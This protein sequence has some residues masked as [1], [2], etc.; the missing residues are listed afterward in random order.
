MNAKC[1]LVGATIWLACFASAYFASAQTNRTWT[2]SANSDWFNPG[3]WNPVGAPGSNDTVNVSNGTINLT[4]P[5]IINGQL[6]WTGGALSGNSVNITSNGLLNIGGTGS[7]TLENALTNAGTV[8][9]TGTVGIYVYNDNASYSGLIQNLTGGVWNIQSDQAMN[10]GYSYPSFNNAGTVIKSVTTGI[11]T[12]SIAFN[13]TGTVTNLSGTINFSGG[14]A[15]GGAFYAPAGKVFGFTGGSFTTA[16]A[17]ISGAG[18]AQFTGGSLTLLSDI[19]PNLQLTGGTVILG[20]GFQGGTITNLTLAGATLSGTNT[21]GGIMNWTAGVLAGPLT[22]T[23]NGVLSVSGNSTV[24]LYSPLTNA[25]TVNWTSTA[26]IYVYNDHASYSGLIQNLAG[27]VWNIQSDQSMSP[28]YSY[29]SFNNAGSVIKSVTAGTTTFSI[30]FNNTGS[31]T[32]LSGT[33]NFAG[34]GTIGGAFYAA[35]GKAIDFS[36]GNFAS[37]GAVVSGPGTIQ[38]NG[39]SLTL[40][41]DIAPNLQLTGGTVSLGAGFQG[42]TI[43]NFTLAGSTL[44]GTNTLTGIMNWTAG[45]VAGP[46][47]V[48]SNGV[49]NLTGNSAVFLYNPLTNAG[50]VNWTGTVGIYVYNN[51]ASYSGSIQNL[52]GGVWNIQSD[53]SIS[54]G[55]GGAY[56]FSNAGSVIKSVTTGTTTFSI[57]FYNTG[58]VTNLS[59]TLNFAAGGA[60]GETFYA[61]A[62]KAIDFSSGNFTSAGA[63]ISGP[64]TI[65]LNGGSLTLQNDIVP[66]LQLTGGTVSLG[67][68]FQG[69]TIT[70]FALAGSTLSGTNTLT[71]IMNWTAGGVGGPLTVASNGVLNLTGNSTVFLYNPL[72]NAGTVNWTGTVGIYVYNNNAN[73]SGLIQNLAGGVWNIQS[74][75]TMSPG[76]NNPYFN[77]AGTVIKSVTTGTTTFSIPFYNTGMVT[78]LSGTLNFTAGGA[79]GGAFYAAAG[80]AI[81]FSS[82][83]FTSAGAIISGPGTIQLNG[84]NLTLQNDIVP[85]LQLTDGTVNLGA[86]FQGGT[87]TNFTLAGATLSGTNTVSGIL[88]WT[89][90]VV[91]GPLTVASN[92]VLN[93]G[94]NSTVYLYSPLTNAGTVNWTGT[95]GIYVYNNGTS[96]SGLIQNLAGG[97]WNIQ[98]DQSINPGYSNP[99]FSNAGIVTKSVTAGTTTFAIPFYNT[100]T[101]TN[102][103]GT[104][105]FSGG[106]TIGGT[107]YGAAGKTIAFSSGNFSGVADAVVAGPGTIQLNG[108]NLTLPNNIVPNL[109]MT[110]GTVILGTGFQGG[111]IT[112]LTLAGSVLGGSNN[113]VT[114]TFN[115]GGGFTGSL[116]VAGGATMSW[117]GG[118]SGGPLTVAS[119]GVLTLTGNSTVFLYTPLTN[120]GTVN[121]TGTVGIYVY[122]NGTGYFGLI[123]NLAGGV[124]NI[125][126]DQ[127]M[128]PGYSNPYFNNAGIVTKSVTAGTTTFAI[129]FYNTGTVTNLSGT[130]NFAGGGTIGGTFYAAAGKTIDFSSGSFSGLANTVISGPGT[131][132]FNG[133]SLTLQNDIVP[134]LQLTGGTVNLGAGF[135]VGTITNLTLAGSVLGG[136]S[137]TVTGTFNCGGGFTGSLL[138]AGGATMSW[139]GG[140]SGGPLTVASNGVLTLTGN[141]T[142]FLY[143]PLTNAGTVNWTGTV[144]IYV[145][146][147]GTSYSGLIQNLA[148]GLWNIQSDQSMNPGYSYPY[149]S[150]AGLVTKSA[151]TGTTAFSI[152]FTNSGTLDVESGSLAFNGSPAYAQTGATLDFGISNSNSTGHIAISGNVNLDG[153]LGITILN[154]YVPNVGDS[155]SLLSFGSET[156]SFQNLN[157]APLGIGK[158]W[159]VVY[160]AG[161]VQL[162]VV[163]NTGFAYQISGSVND[164][165]GH[166][167]T[168]ITVVAYTTN[169]GASWYVG[170]TTDTSGNYS[171]AVTNG[172]WRVGVQGLPA[173]GYNPLATQSAVVSN[174]NQTVNFVVQPFSGTS[175]TVTTAVNPIG[176]GITT[177]S[178]V[179][180]PGATVTVTATPITTTLPYLFAYWTENGAFESATSS[181]S[182]TASRDRQLLANFTLPTYSVIVS[183][184]PTGAGNVSGA[185]SYFYGATNVLTATP[186]FGY[187]FSNW[188]EGATVVGTSPVLATVIYT[189]HAFVANYAA[190]NLLH[191]ITTATAPPGLAVVSGADTY[192]NGQTASFSAPTSITN[193]PNIFTFQQFTLSNTVVSGAA[194]FN[195]TFSTLDATNLQYVAVYGVRTI[196]PLLTKVGVNFP[197]PVPATT[198]F[199]ITLQFDR[200][201]NPAILPVVVLTNATASL[202]PSVAANGHWTAT[203]QANDTYVTPPITFI[204]GMDGTN[205]LW[206]SGA[207]AANGGLLGLTNFTYFVVDA[208]PPPPALSLIASNSSSATVAWSGYVPPPDLNGFRVFI[209][210]TN[211]TSAALP[212][213]LTV[214]G[215]G[216]RSFPFSA[217]ALDTP[218]YLAVQAVDL[219][220]NGS[221]VSPLVLTLPSSLPPPVS[222]QESPVGATSALLSWNGYNTS[223]LLGFAGFQVFVSGTNFSSVGG[224]VPQAT[225]GP[226]A[227]SYQVNGLNRTNVY[228]FAVVGFNYTNGFNPAVTTVSWSDPYAGNIA[229]NTTIGGAGPSVIPIHHS[230]AVVGGA[231]LTI[232]PGTT[233]LFDPGTGLTVPN[234]SLVANGTALA[235]IVFDSANDSAGG[236]PAP[237]DWN[238]IT[239][240]SGSGSS[241][242]KFVQILYGGGL[243]LDNCAPTVDALSTEYNLPCGLKLQNAATLT[244]ASALVTANGV[245]VE[246]LDTSAL[247]IQNSVL[248]NNVT[249]AVDAGSLPLTATSNWWGTAVQSDVAASLQG[250]VVV[251]PILTDEPL[252]TPAIGTSNGVAQVG[253]PSVNLELACRTAQT[254]RVSEDYTFTGSFFSPFTNSITFPLSAGGGL[255]HVFAQFRSVTGQTNTPVELDVTYITAGPV[256]S[257]FNLGE[258]ETLNRPLI[259]TGSATAALGMLDLEFYVDGVL[260]GTNAGGS[261]SQYFDVRTL[262][263]AIHQVELLARDTAGNI[264]TIENNVVVLVTPP[265]APVITQPVAD[266]GTN[267]NRL[268][269]SG[270]AEP[271]IAIQLTDNGQVLA[272]TNADANGNFTFSNAPLAE[273]VNALLA[274][275]SDSIGIT[276][277]A[278]RHVTVETIPPAALVLGTPVYSPATGLTLTWHFQATGKPATTFQLFWGPTAFSA[279]NQATG[280][281]L[282][283]ST[284]S[285]SVQG[286]A[287]GTYYFGV[288]GYDAVGNPSPLSALVSAV[289]DA[290]PPALGFAYNLPPPVGAGPLGIVLTS[291][292]NL[293][294]T[295]SLTIQPFGAVSPVL[296]SLT[297]VALNTWQSSLNVPAGLPLGTAAVLATA[298][299]QAGN[300]FSGAPSGVPLVIN[301]TPPVG[302]ITTTPPGPIQTTN[303]S[304]NVPISLALSEQV[305][306]GTTPTLSFTPP[307]GTQLAVT[308]GGLGSNWSGTLPLTSAMGSGFGRFTLSAQDSAGNIGTNILSGAQLELYNTALPSPPAAPTNLMATSLPSGQVRLA[309]NVVSNAQIYRLYREPGTNQVPPGVLDLDNLITNSV[310]DLPPAD[311]FYRYGVSASRL[312]AESGISNV[313][314]GRSD[315]TPPAAPTNVTVTLPSSGV[316]ISWQEPGGGETPDHYNLYRNGTRIQTVTS[317]VPVVDYPPR[318]TNTYVVSAADA[319]GNEN[320]S[321]AVSMPLL[322]GTVNNLSVLVE[323]GQAVVLNWADS[324]PTVVGFNVYRNGIRQNVATLTTTSFS[325]NFALADLTQYSVTAVNNA[326]QESPPRK[327]SVSPLGIGLLVN[328]AG[329]GTNHAVLTDYFDQYQIGITNLA[330]AG[331]LPLSQLQLTRAVPGLNPLQIT[332]SLGASVAAG[333]NLQESY[334]IP[335]ASIVAAQTVQVS[336]FQQTDSGGSSVIYQASFTLANVRLPGTQVAV[337]V[338][339][340]PLAGGLTP[341]QVQIYNPSY[342][343]IDVVVSRGNGAQSGDVY[344]SVENSFGQEVSRTPFLGTPLGTIFL[345]D[346]RAY[347]LIPAGSS[348]TFAV[349]NVLVPAALAGSTNTT[350]VVVVSNLYNQIGTTHEGVS[351]PLSGSM[352]SSSL[353]Q[354]PYYGTAQTDKSA[355][356]NADPVLISGQAISQ[357]TGLPVPSAALNIGFATRGYKWYQPVTTDTNGNYHFTYN[358]APGFAGSLSI[359]AADPLVVD[360]LNQ[361]Q[362]TIYRMYANPSTGDIQMSKNGTLSFA[363]RLINPG[364]SL[365]TGVSSSF[366]A[367]QLSGTNQ[368][369]VTKVT[370]TNLAGPSLVIGANQSQTINLELVATIDAPGTVQAQFTFTSAEG[371]SCSFIGSVNLFP[372]VPSLSVVKPSV[373]YLEAS[374]NRGSQL[375]SQI[376]FAN[377][378]LNSLQGV[379]L[380]PPTNVSWMSVNLPVSADGR[381][382]LPDLAMGQS[383]TFSV[384]FNP[385][386]NTP[387]AFYQDAIVIQGTNLASPFSVNVY[388]L[389]TSSLSGNVQFE[390]DDIL[391]DLLTSAGVRLHNNVLQSDAGPFYTDTNGLVT[392][393]N[394]EEGVW[395]WQVTAPGC[396]ASSGTIT[397]IP[398]Q[399]VAQHVRLNRTLVTVN[400]T[401]VPVPFTDQYTIQVNQTYETFVPLPVM[402]LTP[403]YQEFHNV[404]PG[405]TAT[406]TVATKNQGLVQMT[407]LNIAGAQNNSSIVTPLISYLPVLLPMQSVDIPFTVTFSGTNGPVRQDGGGGGGCSA[408]DS[409]IGENFAS[410]LSDAFRGMGVCPQ[411]ATAVQVNAAVNTALWESGSGTDGGLSAGEVAYVQCVIASQTGG[412]GGASFGGGDNGDGGDG[413]PDQGEEPWIGWPASGAG[414]GCFAP[415]TKVLMADG[416]SKPIS[417]IQPKDLVRSGERADAISVVKGIYSLDSATVHELHLAG[418]GNRALTNLIATEEHLVWVDGKGWTAVGNLKAG[419]WLFNSKGD[420]ARVTANRSISGKMRVYTLKLA[421]DIAF[422]AGDVLVHDLC[423]PAPSFAMVRTARVVK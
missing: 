287:N 240:G 263:N 183:N 121:W 220:G 74:D 115:C 390:V 337:S 57:P 64:G 343:D 118:S 146:N 116:L 131:I 400:F 412:G 216:A 370:G 7:V 345:P 67:A 34:G 274:V 203:A 262:G 249:N 112:N 139:S 377:Q 126:S 300:V 258:G 230:I 142:V 378:G 114:G 69:G 415:D 365:L 105:T 209:A 233:L 196:L 239:L 386:T 218:Y 167:V 22:V 251:S 312:G 301:T 322:V 292:K 359:W 303:I 72:T 172:T 219:A 91:A 176:A 252:L 227:T 123:Q 363:I 68:G 339:Q 396:T 298:Q 350:F 405:F 170:A 297:N 323:V 62:G 313:V 129:P 285:D 352:A 197:N 79:I 314:V 102:L 247:N 389:V 273:G 283:L 138:V 136:S 338:N 332:Q 198:N 381:I 317:I 354:T 206:V 108:G 204:I 318:G 334:I 327:V 243:T 190:V 305:A 246:Q 194:S 171:L 330:S 331:S 315:R 310:V 106:G 53:Q 4:A 202:Q 13:N 49:L 193:P 383:N 222:I 85:N 111:T 153:T 9:W 186:V 24:Y 113:T 371:A 304:V 403:S 309:W 159:Q 336:A 286:L 226:T 395:N 2:G 341:F 261:F 133:G 364:D 282:V 117:S 134:N 5:V 181:Y 340:L 89:A 103:S 140:S 391:G 132:Q 372:A 119:N 242:L 110:G 280:R 320:P 241:S 302:R 188:T 272:S 234:G 254:M 328:S 101:V 418:P 205:Q 349:P 10:P 367:Y 155:F 70:N 185:G 375:S 107:F 109:Q 44:S 417:A 8:N 59:G 265:V 356:E 288:I 373:G 150:N 291:S 266:F 78:N 80:K 148:G 94:G 420:R 82:G 380:V 213:A 384:V 95:V 404:T 321:S 319:T 162:R 145:Y 174:A 17:V 223:G 361:A 168:N 217:L 75:Q 360:Q 26:G 199:I 99:Y 238:G 307:V 23:S 250:N 30:P 316:Q 413:G 228:Y 165:L 6:N 210:Q 58:T 408:P 215:P 333:T 92:G 299:D 402:V 348:L 275:A 54:P 290:T 83:N 212:P 21:V 40:Q 18:T 335:E 324:D 244:T 268:T 208:T 264:A 157:L 231:I 41:N 158:L 179:F 229:V 20:T 124:W 87:I 295:P 387:I 14:G 50:T 237:A 93:V 143:T 120:A 366:S 279:T 214:L 149:F 306:L 256:I 379:T 144:G 19:I 409:S 178:G 376:T 65:Q 48:V 63:V 1:V 55:Y 270:T 257:A 255:K 211:Y 260:Q 293:A 296:L 311:G 368:L 200:S 76:Y 406:F 269:I 160:P 35:A 154:G 182:F 394:L 207:Q 104:L 56:Y 151:T 163:T 422:Y 31:V 358:P 128:N 382:H 369:P 38:F 248:L 51:N 374:L 344:I 419:D 180:A 187:S 36:S 61:A 52:A 342:V 388:A 346:G 325:D 156:G 11:T 221:S 86:G 177:G 421:G 401:V 189:N 407:D 98:S 15:I 308:L 175:Y 294:A 32:N 137:N 355:Y 47:T 141:S 147:N 362:I 3:N 224:W 29:P 410:D 184:N 12:F 191:T 45:G 164:N 39:G 195:K 37:A 90:G 357:A 73:Y 385:P 347:V 423:G 192:S 100:G 277:S 235:P 66:N 81:D 16:G 33:L 135:Q 416:T 397:I 84:G 25:G 329:S 351:G 97:V 281:S 259:I 353:A 201:M 232:Q 399:T 236:T 392:I 271:A 122:N 173:R 161:A 326:S 411:D 289:Y 125:Q 42:G 152:P 43:T 27:G 253:S 28:G 77:N 130:L 88:N 245:G 267:N 393:T 276:P 414:D 60:I 398:D 284:M 46:L 71:G 169:S 96:Y 278:A 127:S 166:A 225:L